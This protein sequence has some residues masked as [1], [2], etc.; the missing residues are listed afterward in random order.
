[1][2]QAL[3]TPTRARTRPIAFESTSGSAVSQESAALQSAVET[4]VRSAETSHSLFGRKAEA[5]SQIWQLVNECS[6]PGWDG[7]GAEPVDRL[8]AFKA[9]DVIR[10]LPSNVPLPEVGPEPDGAISLDWTRS[11]SSVFSLSVGAGDRLAY[12][13]LDGSDRG[14][15]VA[16]FDGQAIPTRVLQGIDENLRH[17]APALGTP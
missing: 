1:V 13:W 12:A 8:T 9:A 6:R 5:I 7:Y 2:S 11:R 16:L 4:V 10:A 3:L 15:G 17:A 14:H